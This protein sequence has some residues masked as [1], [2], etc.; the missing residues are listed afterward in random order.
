MWP[1]GSILLCENMFRSAMYARHTTRG[2]NR[3]V[4]TPSQTSTTSGEMTMRMMSIQTYA[5]TEKKPVMVNTPMS[6]IL[7]M[8]VSPVS[9]SGAGI[10]TMHAPQMIMRLNAA[11]PTMVEGPRSSMKY[12]EAMMPMTDSMIS[13]AEEPRAIRVRFATV[14]F[15]TFIFPPRIEGGPVFVS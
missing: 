15:H 6:A 2:K 8:P 4:R 10:A 11:E 1:V 9:A 14:S 5:N 13:G 3:K 7:R 12:S